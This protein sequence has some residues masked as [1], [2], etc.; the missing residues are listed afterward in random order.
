MASQLTLRAKGLRRRS[1][2]MEKPARADDEAGRRHGLALRRG[3]MVNRAWPALSHVFASR[4]SRSTSEL[5][6]ALTPCAVGGRRGRHSENLVATMVLV[7]G[8]VWIPT[9]DP[10]ST[11][12]SSRRQGGDQAHAMK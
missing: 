12:I 9:Q 2:G 10:R 4:A 6:E 11:R 3:R 1:Q 7:G 8:G 5:V